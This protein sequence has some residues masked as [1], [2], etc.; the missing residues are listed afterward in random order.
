MRWFN[1]EQIKQLRARRFTGTTLAS[2]GLAA[3]VFLLSAMWY[4]GNAKES[5]SEAPH[6]T[7]IVLVHGRAGPAYP[8]QATLHGTGFMP[9]GNVVEF[10]PVRIADLP[11]NGSEITFGIPKILP[12]RGEVPPM[13]LQPGDYDVRVT[14]PAGTSN[15][16][17]FTLTPWP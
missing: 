15:A 9:A 7:E 4:Q 2:I 11:S 14:T 17:T 5:R 6:L 10:G 3:A 12:S 16:L 13:V 8:L 1:T